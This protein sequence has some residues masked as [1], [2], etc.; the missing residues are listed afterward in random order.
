MK[1]V[2]A[3]NH[4]NYGRWLPVYLFDLLTTASD[5]YNNSA[6]QMAMNEFSTIALDEVHEQNNIKSVGGVTRLL[7]RQ[8]DSAFRWELCSHDLSK[9]LLDFEEL[10]SHHIFSWVTS[11]NNEITS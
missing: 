9:M 10:D 6:F 5:I 1:K 2:F 4:C 8:E 11:R 3:L 7:N